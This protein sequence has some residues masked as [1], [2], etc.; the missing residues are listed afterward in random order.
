MKKFMDENFLLDNEVSQELYHQHAAKMPIIDSHCHLIPAMVAND[1]KFKSITEL[2]LGGDHYKWRVLRSDGVPENEITD[3][4]IGILSQAADVSGETKLFD[5]ITLWEPGAYVYETFTVKN[6][7]NLALKYMFST[8]S[9]YNTLVEKRGTDTGRS[10]KAQF[11]YAD[12]TG[13]RYTVV[14][15]DDE[16]AKG[17]VSLRDMQNS[18]QEEVKLEEVV[19]KLS[20]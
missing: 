2:W 4:Y 12:K 11:K 9:Q 14:I 8:N 19:N 17:V 1:H 18:S 10:L 20:C 13:S 7:G 5:D 6:V 16:I 3:G 15:G